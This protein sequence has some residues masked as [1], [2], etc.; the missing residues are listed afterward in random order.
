M[1]SLRQRITTDLKAALKARDSERL[2]VLRL[3]KAA[4]DKQ[5]IDSGAELVEEDVAA[6]VR[7]QHKQ[8]REAAKMLG[9]GG[10]AAD[11]A[12]ELN[13]A[14]ILEDYM[15]QMLDE[16]DVAAK[17]EAA[18]AAS[19]AAGPADMGKVMGLLKGELAGRADM[20]AVSGTVR[21]LLA[22]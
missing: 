5:A 22:G 10:A 4:I 13:E 20:K 2:S 14:A 6:V 8:R 3:L 11:A 7:R 15:P 17:I 12:R 16:A 19:G 18:I 1:S 21:K 9:D